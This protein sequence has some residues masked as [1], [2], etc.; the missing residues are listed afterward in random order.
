MGAFHACIGPLQGLL[1]RRGKHGEEPGRVSAVSIDQGLWI[2]AVVLGLRHL[3][4]ATDGHGLSVGPQHGGLGSA[5]L[6]GLKVDIGG[7]EPGLAAVVGLPVVG[8][9]EHHALRE[10]VGEGLIEGDQ[11]QVAHDLGPEARIE[12]MEN[13]M[14]NAPDVLVHRHPVGH[15][16]IDHGLAGIRAAVAHVVPT[17]VDEGVHGVGL[18]PRLGPA[19][20]AGHLEEGLAGLQGVAAAIRHKVIWQHHGQVC[21]GHWYLAAV[22]AV[23]DGNGCAPVALTRDAPVTQSD[24]GFGLSQPFVSEQLGH[25]LHSSGMVEPIEW[26]RGHAGHALFVGIPLLPGGLG[27][28]LPGLLNDLPNGQSVFFGKGEVALIVGGHAHDGTIPIAHEHIVAHPDGHGLAGEG[29]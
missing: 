17:R 12:Q 2:N 1:G 21:L 10:Q 24:G 11:A 26:A 14:L 6:I 27:K 28:R 3:L 18:A 25:G 29:V 9:V 22:G 4:G 20:G 5:A 23:N 16:F 8:L 7:V 19:C 13:G 15:A